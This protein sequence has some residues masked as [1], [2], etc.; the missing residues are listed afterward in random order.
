M[1]TQGSALLNLLSLP[2]LIIRLLVALW[3]PFWFTGIRFSYI[4]PDYRQIIVRMNLRFYNKNIVGIQ[5]G[6]NLFSMTDPCYMI[7]LIRNMG[8]SYK[9][10]DQSA[11]IEFVNPGLGPVIAECHLS[12]EDIDDITQ[13]TQNGDKC[14]KTFTVNIKDEQDELV[15]VVTRVVYI[16]KKLVPSV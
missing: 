13:Q 16:R 4:S 10:I 15:A 6:G 8:T 3:P 2:P 9:I 14:L 12:Q 11:A 5:Y 1:N 7:M